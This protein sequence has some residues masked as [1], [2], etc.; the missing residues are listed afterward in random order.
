MKNLLFNNELLTVLNDDTF[1]VLVYS[2]TCEVVHLVAV[3]IFSFYRRY[4]CCAF[5]YCQI[6]ICICHVLLPF[7][8][9]IYFYCVCSCEILQLRQTFCFCNIIVCSQTPAFKKFL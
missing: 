2:L 8:P 6:N 7:A 9:V 5:R 3:S 1:V 4:A